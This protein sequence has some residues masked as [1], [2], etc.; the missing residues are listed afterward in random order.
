[1]LVFLKGLYEDVKDWYL[2]CNTKV[3]VGVTA[4]ILVVAIAILAS[5]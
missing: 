2:C 3:K 4:A 5:L 1:M